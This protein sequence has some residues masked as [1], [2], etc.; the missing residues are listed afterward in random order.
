M[1]RLFAFGIPGFR[2][3]VIIAVVALLFY[4]RSGSRLLALTPYGRALR[5]WLGLLPTARPAP[6]PAP[7][8]PPKPRGRLFWALTLTAAA[9]LAAW[10][11]TRVVI[12]YSA[13][14]IPS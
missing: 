2:G 10:V 13:T 5:P 1:S 4:G 3:I 14:G 12:H 9:A 7:V 8:A 6:G 11:A